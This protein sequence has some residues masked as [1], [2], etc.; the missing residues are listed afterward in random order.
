MDSI[1][2]LS[3]SNTYEDIYRCL[4]EVKEN[5]PDAILD[6]RPIN[7]KRSN[8]IVAEIHINEESTV[9]PVLTKQNSILKREIPSIHINDVDGTKPVQKQLSFKDLETEDFFSDIGEEETESVKSISPQPVEFDIVSNVDDTNS[10]VSCVELESK[11]DDDDMVDDPDQ[12]K[13]DKIDEVVKDS[14]KLKDVELS[15]SIRKECF[16]LRKI[17]IR[18]KESSLSA[19]DGG[20]RRLY[21]SSE[22]YRETFEDDFPELL[23]TVHKQELQDD[24]VHV[25][26]CSI[27]TKNLY[28]N[29]V[30]NMIDD[31]VEGKNIM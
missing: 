25:R 28:K 7:R 10:I 4:K 15:S 5:E 14:S 31:I 29:S 19:N 20:E 6:S 12:I 22:R 30:S 11:I 8:A 16:I 17:N 26:E 1:A 21:L 2:G 13:N 18:S 24:E 9:K 23:K 3:R 27:I